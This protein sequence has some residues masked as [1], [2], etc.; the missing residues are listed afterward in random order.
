M[1]AKDNMSLSESVEP[2]ADVM[3]DAVDTAVDPVIS[4]AQQVKAATPAPRQTYNVFGFKL[5]AWQILLILIILV[6]LG[7]FAYQKRKPSSI[8]TQPAV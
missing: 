6:G 2:V 8:F 3:T 7:Y 5:A 1:C 4:T